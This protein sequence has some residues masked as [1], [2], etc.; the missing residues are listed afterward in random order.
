MSGIATPY[1]KIV[2]NVIMLNVLL[3]KEKTTTTTTVWLHVF[4]VTL[5]FSGCYLEELNYREHC[6][7]NCRALS[8]NPS[9]WYK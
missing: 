3:Y 1:Y 5:A 8:I 7:I 6:S 2:Y 9:C 4:A